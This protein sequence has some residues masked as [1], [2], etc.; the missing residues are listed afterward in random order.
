MTPRPHSDTESRLEGFEARLQDAFAWAND[1]GREITIVLAVVLVAGAVIAGVLELRKQR[2]EAAETELADIDTRFAA[3]MGAT[4][5][6]FF[7]PEPANADQAKK[8]REATVGELDAFI[9][10]QGNTPL[11]ALAGVK[12]AELEVDLGQLDAADARLAKLADGLGADDPRKAMA[13]RLRGY[14]LDQKGQAL[15]AG[16]TYES[17]A[18]IESYVARAVVWVSAGDCYARANEPARAVAAYREALEASPELGEQERLLERIGVQQAK[19]DAAGS[20]APAPAGAPPAPAA[21][22]PAKP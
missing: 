7:V 18:K 14:V 16:E 4:R 8:A 13:L 6:D 3:A 15:A 22:A 12:A 20:P 5:G 2:R 9:A 11:A 10:K 17:A 1:H 21:S 19:V